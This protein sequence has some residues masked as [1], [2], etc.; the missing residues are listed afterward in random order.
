MNSPLG[1]F[2]SVERCQR[3]LGAADGAAVQSLTNMLKEF[4]RCFS[5]TADDERR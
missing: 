3:S 1:S 2:S 5:S 4:G